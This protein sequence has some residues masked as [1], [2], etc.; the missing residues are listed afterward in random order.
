MP[1][2]RDVHQ[3]WTTARRDQ[4]R[5]RRHLAI[6]RLHNQSMRVGELGPALHGMHASFLQ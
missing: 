2:A 3:D 1:R 5:A 6:A 4:D